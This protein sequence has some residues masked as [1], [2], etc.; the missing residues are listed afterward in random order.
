MMVRYHGIAWLALCAG[1]C[2]ALLPAALLPAVATAGPFLKGAGKFNP[3]QPTVELFAG[4]DARQLEARLIPKDSTAA[5]LFVT[6]KT[7]EAM[8]VCVPSALAAV[9]AL[10][11]LDFP[12]D[13]GQADRPDNSQASDSGPQRLGLG[14]PGGN[15][16]GGPGNQPLFNMPDGPGLRP[17]QPDGRAAVFFNLAPGQTAQL[18]LSA[19]CLDYGKPDPRPQFA[20]EVRPI[21]EVASRPE[22]HEICRML[23]RGEIPQKVAQAAAWH[24]EGEMDWDAVKAVKYTLAMGRLKVPYFTAREL[25]DAKKAVE[26]VARYIPE[27]PSPTSTARADR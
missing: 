2:A 27:Q 22:M 12:M 6:N 24:L 19:V 14:M 26:Q 15:P 13:F 1:L 8:N 18:R 10:A 25:A 20:Y 7:G 23:G 17:L 9:P 16:G 21:G 11:Q 5:R 3:E 4:L